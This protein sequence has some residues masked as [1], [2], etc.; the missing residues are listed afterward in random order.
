MRKRLTIQ[1]LKD[2]KGK[3]QLTVVFTME[4][5]V[6]AACDE[7]GIEMMV[8]VERVLPKIRASAPSVFLTAA[9]GIH[10]LGH[11]FVEGV[12]QLI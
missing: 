1:D 2:L 5:E 6:A 9:V 11:G 3:H 10:S 4:E 8:T 7:A 12:Q